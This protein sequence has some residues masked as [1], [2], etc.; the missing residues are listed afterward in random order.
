MYSSFDETFQKLTPVLV[1]I[2]MLFC[3]IAKV[4][5]NSFF[6]YSKLQC[7]EDAKYIKKNNLRQQYLSELM[8]GLLLQ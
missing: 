6:F 1:L 8:H 7:K 5:R 4:K 2:K 3:S